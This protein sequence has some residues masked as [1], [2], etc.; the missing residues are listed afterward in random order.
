MWICSRVRGLW[1]GKERGG[2]CCNLPSIYTHTQRT[3]TVDWA[4]LAGRVQYRTAIS[5]NTNTGTTLQSRKDRQEGPIVPERR[6][7]ASHHTRA[8]VPV[9]ISTTL[10][11]T[12]SFAQP[13][14][15]SPQNRTV[16][17]YLSTYGTHG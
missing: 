10:P 15:E 6:L 4:T 3:P 17:R 1:G 7:A 16:L 11:S 8:I 12:G 13:L 9:D 14:I 5:H 2:I